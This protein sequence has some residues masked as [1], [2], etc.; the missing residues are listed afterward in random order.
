MMSEYDKRSVVPIAD[1]ALPQPEVMTWSPGMARPTDLPKRAGYA[2]RTLILE[3]TSRLSACCGAFVALAILPFGYAAVDIDK[4][5]DPIFSKGFE[6]PLRA[7]SA[8]PM[9]NIA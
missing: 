3:G 6:L 2:L 8:L 4:P 9:S 5:V 7:A 1:Q